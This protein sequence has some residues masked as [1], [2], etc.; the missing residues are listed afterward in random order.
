[1]DIAYIPNSVPPL[2]DELLYSLLLRIADAN[3][4]SPR[5][6]FQNLFSIKQAS[7]LSSRLYDAP[8]DPINVLESLRWEKDPVGFYTSHSMFCGYAPFYKPAQNS[9]Y[10]A[11]MHDYDFLN[12]SARRPLINEIK[13]CPECIK[14]D[15]QNYD[16]HYIHRAH[17]MSGVRTCWKHNVPLVTYKGMIG[18]ELENWSEMENDYTP[19]EEDFGYALFAKEF[20]DKSFQ[21]SISSIKEA[22]Q[23][24]VNKYFKGDW[25]SYFRTIQ[26]NNGYTIIKDTN[27]TKNRL[28]G[29]GLVS[30]SSELLFLLYS[31]YKSVDKIEFQYDSS[32][33]LFNDHI[34]DK[35]TLISSYREDLVSLSC[36]ECGMKFTTTPFRILSGWGCPHCDSILKPFDLTSRLV[37][38]VGEK[39]EYTLLEDSNKAL[40]PIKVKHNKCG[41]SFQILKRNF[42][43]YGQRCECENRI[44][45][46]EARKVIEAK[47]D[48]KLIRF[49][50]TS[51]PVTIKHNECGREFEW[52]YHKFI[53]QP[54]CK[55]CS[56]RQ[57]SEK[58]F[59]QTMTDLTGNEY[60]LLSEYKDKKTAIEI[61][62]EK[63]GNILSMTPIQFTRGKRCKHCNVMIKQQDIS[64]LV[65]SV[66]DGKLE[67][68]KM[69]NNDMA[70]VRHTDSNESFS[71]DKNY[72]VQEMRR[73]TKGKYNQNKD[74]PNH[75]KADYSLHKDKNEWFQSH[76]N[77]RN[78]NN[79]LT[80]EPADELIESL[81]WGKVLIWIRHHP[82][83]FYFLEDIAPHMEEAYRK[84]CCSMLIKV[85]AFKSII[86]GIYIKPDEDYTVEEVISERYL[87]RNGIHIGYL[88]GASFAYDLGLRS[89]PPERMSITTNKESMPHGRS[90]TVLDV[91]LKIHGSKIPVTDEN[92]VPLS[93]LDF[94][95]N[96]K[97]LR[98]VDELFNEEDVLKTLATFLA[99]ELF[100]VE[101]IK[102]YINQTSFS[103]AMKKRILND[104]EIIAKYMNGEQENDGNNN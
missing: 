44:T 97:R 91:P 100:S 29:N 69:I 24:G 1:M 25:A 13:L 19:T 4:L 60:T 34:K 7:E 20:L 98:C 90:I 5:D 99:R 18:M 104:L 89:S 30:P 86:P 83:K 49:V 17:Q 64:K 82:R 94:M 32:L 52:N 2:P 50:N 85:N 38:S 68:I 39:D 59:I 78:Q 77:T 61:G 103:S 8:F 87:T 92:F 67:F 42:F 51:E 55:I 28:M 23:R 73:P 41:K 3:A 65:S 101:D 6:F 37:S 26:G 75:I 33:A 21:F 22:I 96:W 56:P 102:P 95:A 40:L 9:H 12:L 81:A 45:E 35:Y 58:E 72:L 93:L 74:L 66:S 57:L 48:F 46:Q 36:N 53:K 79:W 11:I 43:D 62:H 47:G 31:L 76:V 16:T 70:L 71:I 15:M 27:Y 63:C 54:W 88:T 84:R 14:N 80:T 10:V